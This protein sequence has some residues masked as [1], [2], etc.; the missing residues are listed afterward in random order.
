M[1]FM[2]MFLFLIGGLL[3]A[4]HQW[5]PPGMQCP[6]RTLVLFERGPNWEKAP[7]IAQKHV[8]YILQQMKSGNILSSG[9]LK[10]AQ[11]AA[12]MLLAAGDWSQVEAILNSE[13]YTHEGVLK[14]A[15]HD[16]WNACEA[17]K[18]VTP[19]ETSCTLTSGGCTEINLPSTDPYSTAG[20]FAG[21]AD[22]TIRQDPQTG[23]LWM[24]YSWPHTIRG[25]AGVRGT[26]VLDTHVACST[27]GGKTWTY[28]GA[29]YTSQPVL[30]PVTGQTDYTAHEVMNLA[31]QV[32][33]R[34]TYW[35]GIHSVYNVPQNSGGGSGLENYS[36]RWEIAM[37]PGAATTGPMGLAS[38]TPQY[39][40][41][42]VNTY[43]QYFPVAINLSSLQSEV[44]GCKQFYEPALVT[45]NNNLYLFLSCQ[46]IG[47]PANMFYAVFKTSDPQGNA[48]NWQ[49]T[50]IPQGATKFANLSDAISASRYL[51]PG[52]TYI[53]Q[54]DV[55]P[56]KQPGTLLAI[57]TAAY[58]KG[59]GKVSLGCVAA[60]LASI[61]P[62]KF[63]YDSQGQ[64]QVDAFIT[65]PDS[66]GTGPGSCTYSPFS[67]TG[68]IVAHKQRSRAPQNNGWFS[69]LMQSLLS[70]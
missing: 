9:P 7:K 26:Q 22:P 57:M 3:F 38:A 8:A 56:G 36:K 62:P 41:Q 21:Y 14:I 34:V 65:S 18:N 47:G 42:S 43:S 5:P 23:T 6:Q 2:R 70:P 44:S 24:A 69:F 11:P 45:S 17:A 20:A 52:A 32:V 29:L 59:G 53:T 67:A 13:P 49:W 35:Y 48:P 12:A 55:A 40:G 64:V 31:P 68:M 66:Q 1:L 51:G 39:L 4:Q 37:A 30:N 28:K 25:P 63:I 16:V 19:L 15:S 33:N 27:D 10:G 61:D 46:A 54:M 60:E 50:Y 58:N